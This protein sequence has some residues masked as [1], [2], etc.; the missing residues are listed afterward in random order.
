MQFEL[1]VAALILLQPGIYLLP[2]LVPLLFLLFFHLTPHYKLLPGIYDLQPQPVLRT[3]HHSKRP[4]NHLILRVT[5]H[6]VL[7]HQVSM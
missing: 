4:D 2:E 5:V 3:S 7:R 6:G 1:R